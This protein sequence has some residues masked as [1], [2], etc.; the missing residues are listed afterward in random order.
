MSSWFD[1]FAVAWCIPNNQDFQFNFL[2]ELITLLGRSLQFSTLL[3]ITLSSRDLCSQYISWISNVELQE[4]VQEVTLKR[5]WHEICHYKKLK[6]SDVW[7]PFYMQKNENL[8]L[9][10]STYFMHYSRRKKYNPIWNLA[11][12]KSFE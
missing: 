4:K 2:K 1:A 5:T 8:T 11:F 9:V 10:K 3:K 12:K 7:H 6:S